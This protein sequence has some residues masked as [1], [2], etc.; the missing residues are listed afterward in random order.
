MK[1]ASLNKIV[2]DYEQDLNKI[3]GSKQAEIDILLMLG[4]ELDK[5]MQNRVKELG[6][7]I[8]FFTD[9]NQRR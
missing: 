6:G 2:K 8:S 9:S 5:W 3:Q 1:K 7:D 4:S